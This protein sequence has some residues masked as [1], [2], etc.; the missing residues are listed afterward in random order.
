MKLEFAGIVIKTVFLFCLLVLFVL[1]A[2]VRY[3][4]FFEIFFR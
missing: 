2:S 3:P 4:E 1:W